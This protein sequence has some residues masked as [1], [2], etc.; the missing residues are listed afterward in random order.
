MLLKLSEE[1]ENPGI[2][3]MPVPTSPIAR[4]ELEALLDTVNAPVVVDVEVGAYCTCT[5][6]LCPALKEAVELPETSEKVPPVMERPDKVAVPVP[7]L[8][9]PMLCV[10]VVP[11]ATFPNDTDAG[12]GVSV[13]PPEVPPPEPDP[14]LA[15][16]V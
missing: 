6:T 4:V 12:D 15:L 2:A 16:V 8:V 13:P 1:G 14:L 5:V 3:C 7:V 9:M 11:T 10:A